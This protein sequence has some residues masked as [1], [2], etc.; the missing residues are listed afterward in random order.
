[1]KGLYNS[2]KD[3]VIYNDLEDKADECFGEGWESE[4]DCEQI[5]ELLDFLGRDDLMV[6]FI[7]NKEED[8]IEVCDR[9]F[10]ASIDDLKDLKYLITRKLVEEGLIK[11]CTDTDEV[12]CENT[13]AEAFAEF[14]KLKL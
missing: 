6:K 3:F 10:T 11:D 13:I 5:Q 8:D 14:F 12:D 1:M 9:G 2:T 7:P 4:E